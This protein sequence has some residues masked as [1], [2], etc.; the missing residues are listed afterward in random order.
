MFKIRHC[1]VQDCNVRSLSTRNNKIEKNQAAKGKGSDVRSVEGDAGANNLANR[2]QVSGFSGMVLCI[3]P[4]KKRGILRR[5]AV[6]RLC[7]KKLLTLAKSTVSTKIAATGM[8]ELTVTLR[9]DANHVRHDRTGDRCLYLRLG[10]VLT[11]RAG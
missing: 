10:L 8:L 2:R 3:G 7:A 9:A 4:N 1:T 6:V 11:N 5:R